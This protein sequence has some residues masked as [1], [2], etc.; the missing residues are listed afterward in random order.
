MR[1]GRTFDNKYLS[2]AYLDVLL[3]LYGGTALGRQELEGEILDDVAGAMVSEATINAHRVTKLPP[4]IPWIRLI[5]VDPSVAERPHDECGIV[6][7]YIS[8]TQPVWKRHAFIID[9]LSVRTSPDKWGDIVVKA[10]H[11]HGATVVVETNQGG[12]VV[13]QMLRQSAHAAGLAV[14]MIRESW[15]SKA[16]AVRAEPVGGAYAKGRIHHVNVLAELESQITSWVATESGY[17]PDRMDA[18]VHACAGGMFPEALINGI[19]GTAAIRSA[20][21]QHIP[22]KQLGRGGFR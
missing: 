6:V 10:A 8:Q 15:S 19:P 20:A 5:G 3:G 16:K 22:T 4:G 13:T 17:S 12:N 7:V 1:R 11:E 21:K 9:D 2:E 14:P 18:L